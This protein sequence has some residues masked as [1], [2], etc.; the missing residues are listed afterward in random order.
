MKESAESQ[1]AIVGMSC[2]LPGARN[3]RDYWQLLIEGKNIVGEIPETHHLRL[4]KASEHDSGGAE[5]D[6]RTGGFLDRDQG[7]DS[8]F[9]KMQ[10]IAG[11]SLGQHQALLLK[12]AWEALEDA[13]IVPSSLAGT[14]LGVFIGHCGNSN[15]A[16]PSGRT[17]IFNLTGTSPNAFANRISHFLGA[18]GP[19]M[20]VD[21]DRSS[22]LVAL[23]LAAQSLRLGE[24]SIALVGGVNL[25]ESYDS[26]YPFRRANMLSVEG[27]CRFGDASADG[28]VRS[29][30][31][32]FVV[33][34]RVAD[35]L[36]DTSDRIYATVVS[37]AALFGANDSENLVEPSQAG[38]VRLLKKALSD[39]QVNPRS[40]AYLE[41]HGTGT[42]AG[43]RVELSAL[44]LV[45]EGDLRGAE[46]LWVGSAK[47]NLGHCE[48]AAGIAGLIKCA[49]GLNHGEI[50][51]TVNFDQPNPV[52]ASPS[53]SVRIAN[54]PIKLQ[55]G[56]YVGVSSFGL[57]GTIAHAILKSRGS[58]RRNGDFQ[59]DA[60]VSS[61]KFAFYISAMDESRLL[62]NAKMHLEYV[63]KW[64]DE[65]DLYRY[66]YS[67]F[68]RRERFAVETAFIASNKED[69]LLQ[70]T[71]FVKSRAGNLSLEQGV[72][73]KLVKYFPNKVKTIST[74]APDWQRLGVTDTDVSAPKAIIQNS[75]KPVVSGAAI[76]VA[77]MDVLK[78]Q[79][80]DERFQALGEGKT[81]SEVGVSS[82]LAV[83][84]R[85]QI[86]E[87]L[88]RPLPVSLL[89]DY[90]TL[91]ELRAHLTEIPKVRDGNIGDILMRRGAINR[92]QL[93]EALSLQ[94]RTF[95]NE[96]LG[97]ILVRMGYASAESVRFGLLNQ[98]NGAVAIVGMGCRLPGGV[99]SPGQLWESILAGKDFVSEV[100]SER[101][102]FSK[103]FDPTNVQPG[104][105]NTK[106]GSFIDGVREFDAPFFSISNVE[107]S[108]MDPRQRII[109]EV[110]WHALENAAIN[111]LELKGALGGVFI[112]AMSGDTYEQLKGH[113]NSPEDISPHDSTGNAPSVISGRL[114]YFLGLKGPVLTVDTACSSSLVAIHLACQSLR[115]R[116]SNVALAGGVNLLLTPTGSIAFSKSNMMSPTGRCKTFDSSADGYVRGEGAAVVVLKRLEDAIR[117][118]NKIIATIQASGVGHN[119]RTSGLTVPSGPSQADLITQVIRSSGFKP[120]DIEY[121]EAHG[122]GTELG[123]P[124]E[125]NA[126]SHALSNSLEERTNPLYVSSIKTNLGHL[127]A[128]AGVVGLLK[129]ALVLQHNTIPKH[130]HLNVVTPHMP[131]GPVK[132]QIPKENIRLGEAGKGPRGACVSSFGFSGTNAH[133]VLG[134]I[135]K[136]KESAEYSR[137]F[138]AI[139]VSA[140]SD[141]AFHQNVEALKKYLEGS[142]SENIEDICRTANAGRAKFRIRSVAIGETVKQ[143]AANLKTAKVRKLAHASGNAFNLAFCYTG[144]GS[145]YPGMGAEFYQSSEMFRS[146]ID[147]CAEFLKLHSK[148]D[149]IELLYSTNGSA[150]LNDTEFAQPAIFAIEYAL[151]KLYESWGVRPNMVLGHSIGEYA[152]AVM[153]GVLDLESALKLVS[154]RGRLMQSLPKHGKM[155]ALLGD[156]S[157]MKLDFGHGSKISIAA[158]N[159]E[160]NTV[161]SGSSEEVDAIV[162]AAAAVGVSAIELKVSHAF[163]SPL[164]EPILEDFNAVAS[165]L[166]YRESGVPFFSTLYGRKV[167]AGEILNARYWTDH[168]SC[169]VRFKYSVFDAHKSAAAHF[170]EIGPKGI[171]TPLV[172]K[173]LGDSVFTGHTMDERQS[174]WKLAVGNLA[175]LFLDGFSIDWG[176]YHHPYSRGPVDL[177]Q[178]SFEK[179]VHWLKSVK[180]SEEPHVSG[181]KLVANASETVHRVANSGDDMEK[182]VEKIVRE[183]AIGSGASREFSKLAS[184][185]ELGL[186]SF[187]VLQLRRRLNQEFDV[188]ITT[189]EMYEFSTITLVTERIRHLQARRSA[190]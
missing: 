160:Q 103:Y 85:N 138:H 144:Q 26:Y 48:G 71:E 111:P 7:F 125:L 62:A 53:S 83:E 73:S 25:I 1:F 36:D 14:G 64:I 59:F 166:N 120:S 119:G 156:V 6:I 41:A 4:M 81:F 164:M 179:Q 132:F 80:G 16:S 23:H 31:A 68:A 91:P 79:L 28:F 188:S 122:T 27:V 161:I 58:Q 155:V 141:G 146:A 18:N 131:S 135:S 178:Y 145:Q 69:L 61:D 86:S 151:S 97:S 92:T 186:N 182:M 109:L 175:G 13:G 121:V 189:Q 55:P 20:V 105:M 89:F 150:K 112:G 57:T 99:D 12:L 114:A 10:S 126:L 74:A 159:S 152:A 140:F 35:A 104:K 49:L 9:F 60:K 124:I 108:T 11:Q 116:E 67:L 87:R 95:K 157:G 84:L 163:H 173:I 148:I 39:G 76:E 174:N 21:T 130:L 30:G 56:S 45:F 72:Y 139:T 96:R 167:E 133:A 70:L 180:V 54:K 181:P 147:D 153:A 65:T 118:G 42:P 15:T 17:S 50:P 29:E 162:S 101:W 117:D 115:L 170:L 113:E 171:L 78:G 176:A 184:F 47:S 100:P 137:P 34:K 51:Q 107:A 3:L 19:S 33:L 185:D 128:A 98:V 38:Q 22:S 2:R 44:K 168:I 127:E 143:L 40:V 46:P 110:A 43:D 63:S 37:T 169:P 102:Q 136:R 183:F 106:W 88:A 77:T 190:A 52:V 149:L 32:G 129:S 8:E 187:Q 154:A 165:R 66:C 177:P 24:C 158:Y 123:D 82:A 142:K 90:P 75:D 172:K 5:S 134:Q 94:K 93:N